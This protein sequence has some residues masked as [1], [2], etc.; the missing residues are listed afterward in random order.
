M[1]KKQNAKPTKSI[2]IKRLSGFI[3]GVNNEVTNITSAHTS[4]CH[5]CLRD[6]FD[7]YLARCCSALM[8]FPFFL[9]RDPC[10]S[11]DTCTLTIYLLIQSRSYFFFRFQVNQL[12]CN[13]KFLFTNCTVN[14]MQNR[15]K[16]TKID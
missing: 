7:F 3:G 9:A 8:H 13:C 5:F 10:V 4:T 15:L 14:L 12:L 1:Q 16:N 11:R 2:L 6:V